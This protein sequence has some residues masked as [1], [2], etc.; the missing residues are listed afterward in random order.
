MSIGEQSLLIL[1]FKLIRNAFS[2]RS[3]AAK[4]YLPRVTDDHLVKTYAT[5]TPVSTF[6]E[7]LAAG[8]KLLMLCAGG[9]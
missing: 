9:K 2:L 3:D 7:W 4:K 1:G 6:R 5:E 8:K